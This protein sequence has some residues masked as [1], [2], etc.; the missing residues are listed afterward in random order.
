MD[1]GFRVCSRIP[2]AF[3]LRL[4][5]YWGSMAIMK[6]TMESATV[7]WS[8]YWDCT[9]VDSMGISHIRMI[10][11]LFPDSLLATSE[12]FYI[13]EAWIFSSV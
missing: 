11:G 3:Y 12:F 5:V 10:S 6:K 7:Q 13:S 4:S 9:V 1:L 8:I 2:Q